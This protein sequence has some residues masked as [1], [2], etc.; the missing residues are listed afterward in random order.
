M[1]Q[2]DTG[3]LFWVSRL[4]SSKAGELLNCTW[5]ALAPRSGVQAKRIALLPS[6]ATGAGAAVQSRVT[7]ADADQRPRA[8]ALTCTRHQY[9]ACGSHVGGA[10]RGLVVTTSS[11]GVSLQSG[12]GDSW[13]R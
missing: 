12:L 7:V 11:V 3:G 13:T 8:G 4:P 10:Y 2:L 6:V 5:Y 1:K 9:A